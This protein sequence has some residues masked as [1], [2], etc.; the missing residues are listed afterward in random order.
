M[1]NIN[2]IHFKILLLLGVVAIMTS[3]CERD[4]SD[5]AV[6]ATFPTTGEIFTD[7]FIGLG[8]DFYFPF[9]GDGAKPDVFS[10]DA[11]EGFESNASIRIDVPN[12][13]DPEGGFAGAAF[14]I[15]GVGRNL[16]NYDA[17]TFY[18]KASQAVTVGALG[19]GSEF[20]AAITDTKLTT[21]WVK[22]IIPIPDPSKL[23]QVKSVFEFS[24]GGILP[25][26][27]TP[28][29]GQEVGYS[30]W[31]DELKFEKLGTVAQP[32]PAINGGKDEIINSFTGAVFSVSNLTQT[33]NLANGSN[34]TVSATPAYFEFNLSND[35]VATITE[36]GE[37]SVIGD[38]TVEVTAI[39][40]NVEAAG[41]LTIQSIGS[42]TFPDAPTQD[43]SNV[44]SIFSDAYVSSV[45][46][47]TP[48]TF[49]NQTLQA[50]VSTISG[51]QIISYN[52]LTFVGMGWDGSI[53]V[54]SY[55][56]L[57]I[58]IQVEDSFDPSV[59]IQ[60]ELAE[61]GGNAGGFVINGSRLT[62]GSWVSIDIPTNG[63]TNGTGGGGSG[64]PNL[65]Q[66]VSIG[67]VPQQGSSN[68]IS[69]V[70]VDNVY[71]YK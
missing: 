31:I 40:G 36:Q 2:S 64:N 4:L 26:G 34:Q 51:N 61:S 55:G 46:A 65:S 18:A 23:T 10:V 70:L 50:N 39:L 15:D 68:L 29:Q 6:P 63:F 27:A 44:F 30:F 67:F 45:S 20:R 43:A 52:N 57:H 53:D 32:R 24:A 8:T 11:T 25:A 49:N 42:F 1:K 19:F 21:N 54:S 60:I 59:G 14:V 38:G 5:E 48:V 12:A 66:I 33:F 17:L 58:D 7:D 13:D 35:T 71:F 22:Y 16:T 9:V 3:S 28:G 47:F 41:S 69:S 56:T 37:I 62:T